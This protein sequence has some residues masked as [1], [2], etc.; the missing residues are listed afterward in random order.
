MR[1]AG[2]VDIDPRKTGRFVGGVPVIPPAEL[3]PPGTVF[4]LGYVGTRG[5]RELIRGDLVRRV[6]VKAG[7]S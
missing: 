6:M 1:I 2:Y 7:I 4:V 3:P 5:A